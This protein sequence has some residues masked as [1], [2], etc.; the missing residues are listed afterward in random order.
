MAQLTKAEI[1]HL[2]DLA[3][4]EIS[5][6]EKEELA[7]RLGSVLT[8][9]SEISKITIDTKAQ[10]VPGALRNVL[11]PDKDSRTGG[12]FTDAIL[13]NVPSVE[14]GYVKVQRIL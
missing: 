12:E 6:E 5:E 14:D 10:P 3:R 4:I 1:E 2:A 11:R 7:E 13:A 8:Y 9:V